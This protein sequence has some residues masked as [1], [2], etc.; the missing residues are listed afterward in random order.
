MFLKEIGGRRAQLPQQ[1]RQEAKAQWW[2]PG[3]FLSSHSQRCSIM[4]H[5]KCYGGA[6]YQQTYLVEGDPARGS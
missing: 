2:V 5:R 6:S 4:S 1:V 3:H